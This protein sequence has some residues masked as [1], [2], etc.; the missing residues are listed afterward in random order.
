[1]K[2]PY[3]VFIPG[4]FGDP[5]NPEEWTDRAET[6]VELNC[7]GCSATTLPYKSD[8]IFRRMG[9]EER[10]NNLEKVL[11]RIESRKLI[12]VAHSN[13]GDIVERIVKRKL[14][15]FEE[16]HLIG[17][18]GEGDFTKNGFNEALKESHVKKIFVYWSK[19]DKA[20]QKAKW[21]SYFLSW[22][23]LGYGYLGLTGPKKVNKN[24]RYKVKSIQYHIDHSEYFSKAEFPILMHKITGK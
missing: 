13:G 5:E 16:I 17:S 6:Y 3:Y 21:S 11:T 2:K 9:Q 23:G 1:M 18:A 19:K 15:D 22:I 4:I 10:V 14:F 24:V 20:L 12:L 7:E 8:A